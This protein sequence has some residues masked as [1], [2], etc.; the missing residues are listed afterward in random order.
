VLEH[1]DLSSQD[2]S[3]DSRL[4]S[5]NSEK[6]GKAKVVHKNVDEIETLLLTDVGSPIENG[7][8]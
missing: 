8:E 3:S 4:A 1:V 2:S 7:G 6:R 5:V